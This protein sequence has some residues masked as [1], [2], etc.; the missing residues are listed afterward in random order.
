[1]WRCVLQAINDIMTWVGFIFTAPLNFMI[2][3]RSSACAS[4]LN[5][6][7][8]TFV[9][10]QPNILTTLIGYCCNIAH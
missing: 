1:M 9:A 4:A 2:P 5:I 10:A 6:L 8:A 7:T 3:V